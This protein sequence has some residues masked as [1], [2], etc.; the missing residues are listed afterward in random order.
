MLYCLKLE[1]NLVAQFVIWFHDEGDKTKNSTTFVA[2]FLLYYF[3]YYR[4]ISIV[5]YLFFQV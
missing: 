5:F 3:I 4:D 1:E 2:S